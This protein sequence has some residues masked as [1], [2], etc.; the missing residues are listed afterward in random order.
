MFSISLR[1]PI[2]AGGCKSEKKKAKGGQT[3]P[4]HGM[5]RALMREPPI[6]PP[7]YAFS[8]SSSAIANKVSPI[9]TTST[10]NTTQILSGENWNKVMFDARRATSWV[11]VFYFVSLIIMGMMIVMNLFLAILLSNFTNKDDVDAEAGGAAGEARNAGPTPTAAATSGATAA[12]G[13]NIASPRVTPYS[14]HSPAGSPMATS[15]GSPLPHEGNNRSAQTGGP[16]GIVKLTSVRDFKQPGEGGSGGKVVPTANGVGIMGES[17]RRVDGSNREEKGWKCE[18][19]G[20]GLLSRACGACCSAARACRRT[21]QE[22]LLSW[23]DA[24]RSLRVP[25]DLEPGR[26]MLILGPQNPIRRGCAAIV[27]NPGFDRLTLLLISV[28]SI[29]LAMDSPLRDDESTVAKM[30]G[31]VEVVM[32]V[33][34]FIEMTLKI[35]AQG[36]I[37]MP[38]AYLRNSWNVLDFVVVVISLFQLFS[39]DSGNL[40]SLRSLRALR[41]LRPLR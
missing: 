15:P 35:C 37:A 25:D 41:A 29:A 10:A 31:R 39:D 20:G 36:F 19:A 24:L 21:G 22:L 12:A 13:P 23:V 28:S 11:S 30:L 8:H 26:A 40:K 34:F 7:L 4:P 3:V 27:V 9:A 2:S 5:Q 16:E 6:D 1:L 17:R 18:R 32:T 33:L 14:P 38:G